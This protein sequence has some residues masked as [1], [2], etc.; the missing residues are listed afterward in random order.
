MFLGSV[1]F[2]EYFQTNNSGLKYSNIKRLYYNC[3]QS[4]LSDNNANYSCS[5]VQ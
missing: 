4:N 2:P 5:L 1:A 3:D